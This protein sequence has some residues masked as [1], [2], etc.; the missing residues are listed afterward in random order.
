MKVNLSRANVYHVDDCDYVVAATAEQACEWS[1]NEYGEDCGNCAHIVDATKKDFLDTEI[2]VTGDVILE[3]FKRNTGKS[4]GG[5]TMTEQKK[6]KVHIETGYANGDITDELEVSAQTSREEAEEIARD[7]FNNNVSWGWNEEDFKPAVQ[8]AKVG[9]YYTD[10]KRAMVYRIEKINGSSETIDVILLTKERVIITDLFFGYD[11]TGDR[12]AT[13]EEIAL[14]KRAEHF[15]SKGRKLNEFEVFD[16]AL[17]TKIRTVFRVKDV[18]S[19]NDVPFIG[20]HDAEL[21][22]PV[23]E[24]VIFMTAEELEAATQEARG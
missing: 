23:S 3:Y 12:P 5:L 11:L 8:E 9:E 7:I 16:F 21:E 14:F 24:C 2:E 4:I 20:D 17:V 10:A 6:V 19:R 1:K 13:T 22:F 18:Y 15:H